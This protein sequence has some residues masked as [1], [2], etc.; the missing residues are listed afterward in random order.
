[1]SGGTLIALATDEI[2][3]DPNAVLGPLDPQ[4]TTSKGVQ[5]PAPSVLKVVKEKGVEK[6]S[7]ETL[8]LADIAEKAIKQMQEIIVDIIKDKYDEEK[9]LKIAK[10]HRR[11]PYTQLSYNC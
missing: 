11:L 6:V 4:I 1:M 7:D 9:A 8:L 10:F 3:V 5:V 2:I